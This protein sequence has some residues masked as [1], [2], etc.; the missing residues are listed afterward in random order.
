MAKII[1]QFSKELSNSMGYEENF[2]RFLC[3]D[4]NQ[5]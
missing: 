5:D 2:K 1:E 3:S 4:M